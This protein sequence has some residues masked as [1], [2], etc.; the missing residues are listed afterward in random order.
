[1]AKQSV[2]PSN[3]DRRLV[4][5]G[6][7]HH[8]VDEPLSSFAESVRSIKVAADIAGVI[9]NNKVIGVTSTAPREG[10]ST[11]S[12]NFTQLIA[13]A[14]KRVVLV[15]GDLRNPTLTSNLAP[16]ASAGLLEVLTGKVELAQALYTDD[17]TNLAFLPIVRE[18]RLAHTNEILASDAFKNL[19]DR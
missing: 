6:L 1:K 14:G 18:A 7:L 13:H 17:Q 15:D 2:Q 5:G 16:N 19:I 9:K 4:P 10:K 3:L 8:V 11:V 12:S